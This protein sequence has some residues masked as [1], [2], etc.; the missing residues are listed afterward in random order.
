MTVFDKIEAQQKGKEDTIVFEVGEQ[1][2]GICRTDPECAKIVAED[3]D[4]PEMSIDKA[5]RKIKAW[6]DKQKRVGGGVGVSG[7]VADRILREF[8]GLPSS[9][10]SSQPTDVA[11]E[12]KPEK[13]SIFLDLDSFLL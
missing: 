3:L 2:K 11:Q 13:D 5:E 7:I 4:N 12:P 1:L 9:S 6:A 10:S 8:Y